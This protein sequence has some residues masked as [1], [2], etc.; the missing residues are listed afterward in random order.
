MGTHNINGTKSSKV[1]FTKLLDKT[2]F[3][4]RYYVHSKIGSI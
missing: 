2:D 4:L 1:Y 3:H